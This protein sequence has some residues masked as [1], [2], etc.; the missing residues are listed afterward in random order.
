M[1][2]KPS[3][4]DKIPVLSFMDAVAL[5]LLMGGFYGWHPY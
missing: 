1:P 2:F 5:S 3:C 4:G